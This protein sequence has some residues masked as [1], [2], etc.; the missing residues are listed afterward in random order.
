MEENKLQINEVEST[1]TI[2]FAND[3]LTTIAGIAA[4]DI[5]GVA[6]MSGGIV[7]G[8]VELLGKKNFSKGI[9]VT[10]NNDVVVVDIQI[11]VEYGKCVPEICNNIQTAVINAIETMTGLTVKAVNIAI[12][13]V[14][15]MDPNAPV[16]KKDTEE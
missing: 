10:N 15:I 6:G 16:E 14:K 1:G 11:V 9:K 12:Q 4:S 8:I 13:D 2:T 5:P 3:V 7:D